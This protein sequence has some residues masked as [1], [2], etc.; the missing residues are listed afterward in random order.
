M[1]LIR[2]RDERHGGCSV[3]KVRNVSLLACA[4]WR[5][6]RLIRVS[7]TIYDL[8]NFF[9]KAFSDLLS[10]WRPACVL[11]RVVQPGR[12]CLILISAML[13]S[14]ARNREDVRDVRNLRSLA[15]LSLVQLACVH[16]GFIESAG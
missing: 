10:H 5:F 14:D 6:R 9:A 8:G 15:H 13:Q 7:T 2:S 1:Q 3:A 16:E 4:P 11:D 12:N